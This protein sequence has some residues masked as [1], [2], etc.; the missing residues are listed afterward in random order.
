[1]KF[2]TGTH[3]KTYRGNLNFVH[4]SS[5]S[6]LCSHIN[7]SVSLSKITCKEA[8]IRPMY[9]T[10]AHTECHCYTA[11]FCEEIKV[12][13][14]FVRGVGGGVKF[15]LNWT[16]WIRRTHFGVHF[17]CSRLCCHVSHQN[18]CVHF[19]V[20]L[21]IAGIGE[22][23]RITS[24]HARRT[25]FRS[26]FTSK[27]DLPYSIEEFRIGIQACYVINVVCSLAR[28]NGRY[29]YQYLLIYVAD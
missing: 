11:F 25:D 20:Y 6:Q 29:V 2:R 1:M 22:F 21:S 4:V 19:I 10:D 9:V 28:Y 26:V 7:R 24:L 15:V 23:C 18:M 8:D 14:T 17:S 13:I 12:Q 5:V 27:F 3:T 16:M